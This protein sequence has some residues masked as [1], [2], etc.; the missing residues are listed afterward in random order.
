MRAND[1]NVIIA[2]FFLF[3]LFDIVLMFDIS[4]VDCC[5]LV[6]L[7][8]VGT[9]KSSLS[10]L[11]EDIDWQITSISSS[12]SGKAHIS[13]LGFEASIVLFWY[14]KSSGLQ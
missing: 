7:E 12:A 3:V 1:I 13:R 6:V 2:T 5:S 4:I 14:I 9:S 8:K 10:L 11:E